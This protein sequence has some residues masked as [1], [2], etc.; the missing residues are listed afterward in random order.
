[1]PA[2]TNINVIG[3][4]FPTKRDGDVFVMG[5]EDKHHYQIIFI[6]HPYK[7]TVR[8]DTLFSGHIRNYMRPV[9]SGKGYIG[10][11]PWITSVKGKLTKTYKVWNDILQRCYAPRHENH[12]RNWADVTVHDEWLNF[13]NF[14]PWY[15]KH[16]DSF[17]P[18]N[19]KWELDKDLL[20]PRNRQYGPDVCCVLPQHINSL[21][22][23][24]RHTRG[25]LPLGVTRTRNHFQARVSVFGKC[26]DCGHYKTIR[27][28]R[29]AYWNAKFKSIQS[30]A[31]QYWNYLPEPL[32]FRLLNFDWPDAVAYY[33]D[34]AR[35]WD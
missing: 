15:E 30:A 10:D 22:N 29:I 12:V 7:T 28:A 5:I 14:A 16:I 32:A 34:D 9:V 20:F 3:Q 4:I 24:S 18:V 33:G 11:G 21:F 13:Q 19:F 27:E 1:M 31:I 25:E 35:L 8:A 2:S 17:G 6:E 23:D 26:Q